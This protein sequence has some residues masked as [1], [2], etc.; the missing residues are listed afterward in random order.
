MEPCGAVCSLSKVRNTL[1]A[2]GEGRGE[3]GA[4]RSGRDREGAIEDRGA[5]E[6]VVDEQPGGLG[7]GDVG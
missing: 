5:E 3:G 1:Y 4:E 6:G 7:E 2:C